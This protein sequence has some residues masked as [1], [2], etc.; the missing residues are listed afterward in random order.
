MARMLRVLGADVA[1]PAATVADAERLVA[2]QIPDVAIVDVN[3]RD[4]EP[5][6]ALIDRLWEQRI[7]VVVV[8]GYTTA[9]LP[10]GRVEAILQKPVSV[11]RF[12]AILRPILARQTDR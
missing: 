10:P 9:S 11:E 1:G 4:G 5:S 7:P 6:N 2:E 3:L 12:L 8:T